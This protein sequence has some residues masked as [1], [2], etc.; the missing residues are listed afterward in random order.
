MA[1]ATL[2]TPVRRIAQDLVATTIRVT[3]AA[4]VRVAVRP[5]AVAAAR[6]L[7]QGAAKAT[8]L[9][10]IGMTLTARAIARGRATLP[11]QA[12]HSARRHGMTKIRP[13]Q[14][15]G[16]RTMPVQVDLLLIPPPHALG[17]RK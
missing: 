2:L 1:T 13:H 8:A 11:G 9:A 15:L 3:I 14:L 16:A 6:V 12:T 4:A 10:L 7:A 17:K 5:A